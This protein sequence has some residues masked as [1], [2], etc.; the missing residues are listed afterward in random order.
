MEGTPSQEIGIPGRI[1]DYCSQ[2]PPLHSGLAL[3]A[4]EEKRRML[5]Q[6]KK[7][8][9]PHIYPAIMLALNAGIPDP[10]CSMV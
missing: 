1:L 3:L 5:D 9:S 8:R 7:A 6:A 10:P 4:D 2:I